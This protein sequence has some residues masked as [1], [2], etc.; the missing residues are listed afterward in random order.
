MVD[1]SV[2]QNVGSI[3]L[4]VRLLTSSKSGTR[5]CYRT[6]KLKINLKNRTFVENLA[7][8][9]LA[10]TIVC[11]TTTA[12]KHGSQ[13]S[14]SYTLCTANAFIANERETM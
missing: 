8:R 1:D 4:R 13:V 11:A 2:K 12:V 7:E 14:I 3:K 6:P 9:G 10:D 5:P